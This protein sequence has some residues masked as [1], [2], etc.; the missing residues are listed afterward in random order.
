MK[1]ARGRGD[2]NLR[3]FILQR[4]KRLAFGP[5]ATAIA[6]RDTK[7]L[8]LSFAYQDKKSFGLSDKQSAKKEK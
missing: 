6:K 1:I 8:L 7:K 2:S 4:K 5:F 3:G